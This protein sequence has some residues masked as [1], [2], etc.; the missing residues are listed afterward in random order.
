MLLL[1][2]RVHMQGVLRDGGAAPRAGIQR[3]RAGLCFL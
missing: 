2:P 1:L 3:T